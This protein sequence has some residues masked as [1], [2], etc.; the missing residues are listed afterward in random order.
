MIPSQFFSCR[1]LA[2]KSTWLQHLAPGQ[3]HQPLAGDAQMSSKTHGFQLIFFG[4]LYGTMK[5]MQ[6]FSDLLYIHIELNCLYDT[7][8][9]FGF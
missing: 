4:G 7:V 5:S 1:R 2:P 3:M 8:V 9:G 6:I